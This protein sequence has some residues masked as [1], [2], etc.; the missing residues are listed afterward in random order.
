MS[1][2]NPAWSVELS[3]GAVRGLDK[4]PH[5]VAAAMAEFIIGTLP[6]DPYRM[7]KPLRFELAGWRVARRGDYRIT[8][9]AIDDRHVLYVGRVEHRAHVY[10]LQL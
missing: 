3:A 5:K 6:T 4:L 7:S 9:H 1:D 2:E 8:F 10:R